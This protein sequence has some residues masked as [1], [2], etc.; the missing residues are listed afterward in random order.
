M[1]SSSVRTGATLGTRQIT[2]SSDTALVFHR[3]T[4]WALLSSGKTSILTSSSKVRRSSFSIPV[5]RC[6]RVPH[7]FQI[8][9][10]GTDLFPLPIGEL[11][12]L[13]VFFA[14]QFGFGSSLVLE[15]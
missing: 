13:F 14:R 15:L 6:R 2:S 8:I 12:A 11:Q 4:K 9:P 3:R 10:Q 5:G 7:S 1:V